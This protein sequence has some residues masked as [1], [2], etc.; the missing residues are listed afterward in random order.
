MLKHELEG[1]QMNYAVILRPG[2]YRD[3]LKVV[4]AHRTAKAAQKAAAKFE[5]HIAVQ[6]ENAYKGKP[7]DAVNIQ[8]GHYPAAT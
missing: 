5:G 1:N 4:S 2:Y 8:D 6:M 3:S 7:I